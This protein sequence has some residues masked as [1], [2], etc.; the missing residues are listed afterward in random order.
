MK[1]RFFPTVI[2]Q[3]FINIIY[4]DQVHGLKTLQDIN[5]VS[6]QSAKVY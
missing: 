2:P 1:Q 3:Y 5:F 4:A 6:F